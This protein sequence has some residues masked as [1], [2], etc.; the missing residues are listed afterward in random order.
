[1][2]SAGGRIFWSKKL[3]VFIGITLLLSATNN[4]NTVDTNN[5]SDIPFSNQQVR[6]VVKGVFVK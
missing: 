6:V 3:N 5:L 1:M 2:I 4:E